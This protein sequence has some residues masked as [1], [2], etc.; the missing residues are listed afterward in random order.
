MIEATLCTTA[1]VKYGQMKQEVEEEN[2]APTPNK[3]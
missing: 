3:Y 1:W 2:V